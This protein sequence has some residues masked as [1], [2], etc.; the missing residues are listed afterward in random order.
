[1]LIAGKLLRLHAIPVLSLVSLSMFVNSSL[2]AGDEAIAMITDVVGEVAVIS[3]NQEQRAEIL[4]SVRSGDQIRVGASEL[5]TL[6]YYNNAREYIF[7]GPAD[8]DI[9]DNAPLAST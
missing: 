5:L 1:M 7:S 3:A 8:I 4:M 9:T 2:F 6:V